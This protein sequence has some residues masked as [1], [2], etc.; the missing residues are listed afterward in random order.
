MDIEC[1]FCKNK[2]VVRRG[3]RNNK[4]GKVQVYYCKT[5]RKVYSENTTFM[6]MKHKGEII[7]TAL[8]LYTKNVSLRKIQDHLEQIHG[9]KVS[10]VTVLKWVRKYS[11]IFKE[12]TDKLKVNGSGTI[13]AD[14]MMVNVNGKWV[15]FWNVMDRNTKF[16]VANHLSKVREASDAK[17]IF[18]EVKRKLNQMPENIVTDGLFAYNKGFSKVFRTLARGGPK[19]IRLISFL[20]KINNNPIERLHGSIRERTKVM[21]GFDK[22]YSAKLILDLWNTYYNFIRPHMSL[23]G[24]TPAKASGINLPLNGGNR[25][26]E[27]LKL[28][29]D[30][31]NDG[32]KNE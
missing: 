8:D 27:L 12:F 32:E 10:H 14:E 28:A 5:C 31:M 11:A 24:L 23:N 22:F 16:I 1:R 2:E 4:A 15:W 25:W 6:K 29:I 13:H 7:L 26:L 19:H 3:F 20:D 21:R 17:K 30:S 9:I 18:F